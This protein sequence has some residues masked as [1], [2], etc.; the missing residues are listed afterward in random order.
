MIAILLSSKLSGTYQ[1]AVLAAQEFDNVYVVDS[2]NATLGE[3]ILVKYAAA[4]E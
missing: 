1:S 3:Q 2:M 4:T